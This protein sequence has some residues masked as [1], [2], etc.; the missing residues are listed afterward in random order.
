MKRFLKQFIGSN[1]GSVLIIAGLMILTLTAVSGA[2]IDLGR[3]QLVRSKLQQASDAGA[4]AAATMPSDATQAEKEAAGRRYFALN[5]PNGYM[6]IARPNPAVSISNGDILVTATADV[7]TRF[8]SLLGINTVVS[9][10][11]TRIASSS[12]TT[13]NSYDLIMILDNSGSM[14]L[15]DA[16]GGQTRI[17]ALRNSALNIATNLL[18]DGNTA[19]RIALVPYDAGVPPGA[20]ADTLP[21]TENRGT[22]TSEINAMRAVGGTNSG[23]AFGYAASRAGF[24][25]SM[26][27]DVVRT[28]VW[29]TDGVNNTVSSDNQ[30]LQNCADFKAQGIVVFTIA[31]GSTVAANAG[32]RSLMS[33]CATGAPGTNEGQYFFI[34]PDAATLS[35]TFNSI[36]TTVSN[37]RI[38]E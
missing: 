36:L 20:G 21:L 33:S 9:T 16:G 7:P 38:T 1:D 15:A 18:P 5:F 29:L 19:N 30:T 6:G 3:Q 2:A 31:F 37:L 12:T 27:N 8:V 22:V 24:V 14:G 13:G 28:V 11:R 25:Q 10:G 23:T 32:V 17:A 34:A 35:T 26:R 4:I